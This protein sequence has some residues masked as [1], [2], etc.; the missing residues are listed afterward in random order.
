MPFPSARRT[1]GI[2]N[3]GDQLVVVAA[4]RFASSDLTFARFLHIIAA[5]CWAAFRDVCVSHLNSIHIR[6]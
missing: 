3:R 5:V 1:L 4:Q 2:G 6:L